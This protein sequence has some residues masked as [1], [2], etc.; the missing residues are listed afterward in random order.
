MLRTMNVTTKSAAFTGFPDWLNRAVAH[1]RKYL[2]Y[3]GYEVHY[4]DGEPRQ[5]VLKFYLNKRAVEE[6]RL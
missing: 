3:G 1:F 2:R 5:I 4:A 6:L